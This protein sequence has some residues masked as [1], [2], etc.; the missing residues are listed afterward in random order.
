MVSI[1]KLLREPM[2]H[3]FVLGAGIFFLYGYTG[4]GGSAP[5]EILVNAGQVDRLIDSWVKTRMR[6]PTAHEIAGLIDDHIREEVYYREA[7][8]MGLDRDNVVIRRHLKQKMEFLVQGLADQADPTE[9]ELLAFLET[10]ADSFRIGPRFS[11]RHVYLNL[12]DRG[13]DGW[14]D[15][16]RLLAELESQGAAVETTGLGDPFP[17][18]HDYQASP[19]RDLARTFG[20]QFA[21]Q[22]ASVEPGSWQGPVRSGYGLHLVFIEERTEPRT[23]ELDEVSE[24]VTREWRAARRQA[25]NEEIYRALRERYAITVETPE[26]LEDPVVAEAAGR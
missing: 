20:R 14:G 2:L 15:A 17:L 13:D 8:A 26:W 11:F 23:P 25:A 3:F 6:P 1:S 7:V 12:D 21:A 5:D 10:N 16:M 24:A 9:E 19:E 4:D 22:M 18:P